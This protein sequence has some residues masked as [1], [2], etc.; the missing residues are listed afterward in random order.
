MLYDFLLASL[1][2]IGLHRIY[3]HEDIF[4][5]VRVLRYWKPLYCPPCNAFWIPALV[6][7]ALMIGRIVPDPLISSALI[8]ITHALAIY[9]LVRAAEGVPGLI[10]RLGEDRPVRQHAP[11]T[12]LALPANHV[13]A[14]GKDEKLSIVNGKP[15]YSCTT[16]TS[17]VKDT[18]VE[19]L[20]YRQRVV[21]LTALSDMRP[22]YSLTTCIIDQ[23]MALSFDQTRLV[24]VWVTENF[25]MKTAPE[26]LPDNVQIRAIV[27]AIAWKYDKAVDEDVTKLKEGLFKHLIPLGNATVICHDLLFVSHYL[28]FAKA[29]HKLAEIKGFK[30]FHIAHSVAS[31]RP[32]GVLMTDK[33]WRYMLP[34]SHHLIALS[35]AIEEK[36]SIAYGVRDDRVHVIENVRDLRTMQR[37]SKR[38]FNFIHENR[39]DAVEIVQIYPISATRMV[40]KGAKVLIDIFAKIPTSKRL[41]FVL[42]HANGQSAINEIAILRARAEEKGMGNC[43]L[44]F[45]SEAMPE[46]AVY[47]LDRDEVA[48]LTRYGNVFLMPSHGEASPLIPLE[49][50]LSGAVIAVN[51]NVPSLNKFWND[52]HV[53]KIG[54]KVWLL[55][56]NIKT[57]L[58]CDKF[59]YRRLEP[60]V[61]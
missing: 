8:L 28:T 40:A 27:P 20:S 41:V 49:A 50:G 35:S 55:R 21:I 24:Q 18:Q 38:L 14:P 48:L 4:A 10:A 5:S 16:C 56:R 12:L 53:L 15:V 23:A 32:D 60:F 37:C 57:K 30:W 59:D 19:V 22:G 25:D 61:I 2:S 52:A 6:L 1:A 13:R 51:S 29:I 31:P 44:I 26:W 45:T 46:T 54:D 36:L 42:A 34:D 17:A 39:I 33:S 47:G 43:E 58:P 11:A 9:P 7:A 3:N